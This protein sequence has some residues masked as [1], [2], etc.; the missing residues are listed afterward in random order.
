MSPMELPLW[1]AVAVALLVLFGAG[2][3]MIGSIGL[4]KLQSFYER[5]H[6]ATL[7]TT[8]GATSVLLA[9]LLYFSVGGGR[10]AVHELLIIVII[11]LVTPV[12]MMLLARAALFRDRTKAYDEQLATEAAARLAADELAEAQAEAARHGEKL[13]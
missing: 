5:A 10:L 4:V 13:G 1:A 8:V 2:L 11:P 3:T 9:S 7:G 12:T 6:P